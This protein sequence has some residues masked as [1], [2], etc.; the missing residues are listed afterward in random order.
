M[1]ILPAAGENFWYFA[2]RR[3]KIAV[4][5]LF[6]SLQ[7]NFFRS[8]CRRKI[9]FRYFARH[10]QTIVVI[11]LTAGKKFWS[12]CSPQAKFFG[13]SAHGRRKI[14]VILPRYLGAKI[15]SICPLQVKN[16]GI[17]LAACRKLRHSAHCMQKIVSLCWPQAKNCNHSAPP[18]V[19]KFGHFAHRRRKMLVFCSPQ[20]KNCSH[21]AR[22][23][24]KI[25]SLLAAGENFWSFCLPQAKIFGHSARC[26]CRNCVTLLAAGRKLCHFAGPCL[27]QTKF[28]GI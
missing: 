9:G 1:V 11:L 17:V 28:F 21:P 14:V 4:I 19:Q 18:Q 22:C 23:R 5:L 10:T 8:F 20:M 15:W 26:R 25:A 6:C 27:P 12:L 2:C 16:V 24:Q 7:V 3:W 13:Y